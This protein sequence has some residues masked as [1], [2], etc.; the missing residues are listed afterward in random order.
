ML[1]NSNSESGF[2]REPESQNQFSRLSVTT[3]IYGTEI[4]RFKTRILVYVMEKF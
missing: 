4:K 3:C 1:Q 2:M